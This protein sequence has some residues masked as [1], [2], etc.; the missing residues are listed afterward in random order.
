MIIDAATR[1]HSC[2]NTHRIAGNMHPNALALILALGKRHVIPV[3]PRWLASAFVFVNI[4]EFIV[5]SA[6]RNSLPTH[7]IWV[8]MQHMS[9][10]AYRDT[11]S[12]VCGHAAT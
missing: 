7:F 11:L 1:G 2:L 5:N 8:S 9:C 10:G 3:K 4:R 6:P 12:L